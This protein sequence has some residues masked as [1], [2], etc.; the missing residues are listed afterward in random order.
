MWM[1]T[2]DVAQLTRLEQAPADLK[3]SPDGE[4]SAFTMFV[5]EITTLTDLAWFEK[6]ERPGAETTNGSP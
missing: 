4:H 3:R 5:P 2:G 6:H 1:D